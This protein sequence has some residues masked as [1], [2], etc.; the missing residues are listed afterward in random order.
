LEYTLKVEQD[1]LVAQLDNN[2]SMIGFWLGACRQ[3]GQRFKITHPNFVPKFQKL[4]EKMTSAKLKFEYFFEK[5]NNAAAFKI[6]A[7]LK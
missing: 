5:A 3:W 1:L 4:E 2:P 7:F 6:L